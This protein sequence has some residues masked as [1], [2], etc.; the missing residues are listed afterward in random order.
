MV[1][2]FQVADLLVSHAAKTHGDEIDLIGY[3]GSQAQ[4]VATS[5]PDLDTD[6]ARLFD[7]CL[8]RWLQSESV[9]LH[10]FET[11]EE[12]TRSL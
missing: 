9:S 10:E 11:L 5:R 1:D 4:G 7:E 12:F 8:R 6:D 2:V 3:Y